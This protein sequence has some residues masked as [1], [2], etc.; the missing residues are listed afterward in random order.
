V[1]GGVWQQSTELHCDLVSQ[2]A[3][4][5]P[6]PGGTEPRSGPMPPSP[7]FRPRNGQARTLAARPAGDRRYVAP[8]SRRPLVRSMNLCR[9]LAAAVRG[10]QQDEPA[11]S[12]PPATRWL[13]ATGTRFSALAA[14]SARHSKTGSPLFSVEWRVEEAPNPKFQLPKKLQSPNSKGKRRLALGGQAAASQPLNQGANQGGR[15]GS[16]AR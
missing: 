9:R 5:D 2:A 6:A 14:R 12:H 1:R 7:H 15:A 3:A 8:A 10:P 4:A 16:E 11:S 13:Q